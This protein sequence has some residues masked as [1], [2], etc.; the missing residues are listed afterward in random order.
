MH[1][2]VCTYIHINV[3]ELYIYPSMLINRYSTD[4][5]CKTWLDIET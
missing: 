3:L 2:Y 4:I 5:K 1:M